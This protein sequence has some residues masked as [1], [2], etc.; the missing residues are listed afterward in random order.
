MAF[1]FCSGTLSADR[2]LVMGILNIT[3]DSFSDGGRY[4]DPDKAVERA[5][6]MEREGADILD[7]GAQST[8]PGAVLLPAEEEWARLSPVLSALRSRVTC[9]L[10]VDTFYPLVA[11]RALENGAVILNDVSGSL[12]NDFPALAAHYGAGLIMM[13]QGAVGLADVLSYFA[14]AKK[15]ANAAGL[16][17]T[18]VCLDMG[19]GFHADRETDLILLRH[20]AALAQ[21]ASPHPLLCGASRKRVIA[22]AAGDCEVH[23]RLGGSLALHTAAMLGGARIIRA[24][25]VQETAQ[26][27][28]IA[29]A[30]LET[31]R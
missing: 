5:L 13:A 18:Q 20:T 14:T 28:K 26:A 4:L 27:A 30:L 19:I 12:E 31:T 8:R 22:Y 24:H 7:L 10:S 23:K 17:D 21:A 25:D 16:T 1:S 6:Q 11:T 9:P 15:A 3:P 29:R 2:P